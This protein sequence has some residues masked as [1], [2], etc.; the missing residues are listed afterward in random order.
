MKAMKRRWL[1]LL[2]IL[3]PLVLLFIA[4]EFA[5]HSPR[6]FAYLVRQADM[7]AGASFDVQ[8]SQGSLSGPM[9]LSGVK[10]KLPG[11]AVNIR[12]LELRWQPLALLNR[13]LSVQGKKRIWGQ[14]RISRLKS[15]T[16]VLLYHPEWP[17]A[18]QGR[19]L[20]QLDIPFQNR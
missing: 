17:S 20:M 12:Q 7:R 16:Q 5:L 10:L 3:L 9:V 11:W 1:I 15:Q 6:V 18:E 4:T 19:W 13:Q 14:S 2:L 8:S